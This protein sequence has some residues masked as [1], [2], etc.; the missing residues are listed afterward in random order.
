MTTVNF[1]DIMSIYNYDFFGDIEHTKFVENVYN[2]FHKKLSKRTNIFIPFEQSGNTEALYELIKFRYPVYFGEPRID[3]YSSNKLYNILGYNEKDIK[4]PPNTR[5]SIA[6]PALIKP[7]KNEKLK[8]VTIIH[9]WGVNFET[10]STLDYSNLINADGTCNLDKYYKRQI[11][12]FRSIVSIAEYN[13]NQNGYNSVNIHLPLIGTGCFLKAISDADKKR[14]LDVIVT[15][16]ENT[17][18][19]L[20][21]YVFVKLCI[22][23][24]SDYSPN[25]LDRLKVLQENFTNFTIGVG[26][27]NGNIMTNIPDPDKQKIESVIVNAWDPCSFIGNGGNLD[28]SIDGFIVANANNLNPHF[29]NSSYLH[30]PFFNKHMLDPS[31]WVII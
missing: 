14:C 25:I 23:N 6:G 21:R 30:N 11:E 29:K 28:L 31:K 13:M 4:L 27:Y 16:I 26:P 12:L 15:A 20:S 8:E 9:I 3:L 5:F 22:F 1:S 24:S 2:R 18:Y 10:K 19:K 17:V 7:I